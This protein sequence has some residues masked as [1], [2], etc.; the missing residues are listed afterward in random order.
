MKRKFFVA[1]LLLMLT[2]FC[3]FTNSS[4]ALCCPT[5][6]K[7]ERNGTAYYLDTTVKID[8]DKVEAC[9]IK[10]ITFE[11]YDDE[12]LLG[13][14]VSSGEN[15]ENLL[16]YSAKF[17]DASDCNNI[18]GLRILTC[19]FRANSKSYDN[20]YWVR[21]D[22]SGSNDKLPSSI[23]VTLKTENDIFIAKN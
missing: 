18:K 4:E 15:L 2:F 5:I 12:N 11:I 3:G 23:K 13:S 7:W 17:W 6:N 10:S 8:F 19:K 21:T 22:F 14:A 16:C 20:G 1:S 9:D